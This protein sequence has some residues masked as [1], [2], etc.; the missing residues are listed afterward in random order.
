M[1]LRV[2]SKNPRGILWGDEANF[3]IRKNYQL[4]EKQNMAKYE[5]VDGNGSWLKYPLV[6]DCYLLW[7]IH[8]PCIVI[9]DTL[10]SYIFITFDEL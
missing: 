7:T 1:G 8:P 10:S 2:Y 9:C 6:G 3:K 4:V 5:F